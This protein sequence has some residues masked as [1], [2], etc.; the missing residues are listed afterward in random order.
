MICNTLYN[1]FVS[2]IE[3]FKIIYF[4]FFVVNHKLIIIIITSIIH[5]S[6]PRDSVY[7]IKCHISNLIDH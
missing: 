1:I 2:Y 5:T 7:Y 3:Y 6:I 4:N